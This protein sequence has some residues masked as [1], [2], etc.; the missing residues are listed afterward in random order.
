MYFTLWAWARGMLCSFILSP[1]QGERGITLPSV[2]HRLQ[3]EV[4]KWRQAWQEEKVH[5]PRWLA[6]ERRY[7]SCEILCIASQARCED[8]AAEL[9]S[10]VREKE[11]KDEH[12]REV[13]ELRGEVFVLNA[14]VRV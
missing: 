8:L 9:A 2:D 3:A 10:K 4:A 5:L 11:E 13:E 6:L 7:V 14:K 12:S 1:H